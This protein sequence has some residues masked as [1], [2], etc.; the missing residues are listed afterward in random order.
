MRCK[1][2]SELMMARLDGQLDHQVTAA[3][4]EHLEVCSTCRAEWQRLHALDS[5]L[6]SASAVPAP[7]HLH[8][9]ITTRISR[10]EEVRRAIGGGLTLALGAASLALLMLIPVALRLVANLGIAPAL[11]VGGLETAQQLLDLVDAATRTMLILLDQFAVPFALLSAGTLAVAVLL[12]AIWIAAVRRLQVAG[13]S[14]PR[15]RS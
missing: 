3:L 2:A 11:L 10:R 8:V 7:P 15:R 14:S 6:R 12:N 4:D 9:W 5:L 13:W 1:K